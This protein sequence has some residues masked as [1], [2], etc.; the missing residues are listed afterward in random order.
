M[1]GFLKLFI[2][3]SLLIFIWSLFGDLFFLSASVFL[4]APFLFPPQILFVLLDT[5]LKSNERVVSYFQLKKSQLPALAIFHIPDDEHDVL[6]P[7]EISVERVQDFCNRFLQRMQKV[8]GVPDAVVY[9]AL[10]E[11]DFSSLNSSPS[12]SLPLSCTL[13]P[14]YQKS[15]RFRAEQRWMCLQRPCLHWPL[16]SGLQ[17]EFTGLCSCIKVSVKHLSFG[18]SS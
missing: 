1:D 12:P 5:N 9:Q 7:G 13:A 11:G 3:I 10:E 2:K 6:T 16:P 14:E 4:T 18:N 15:I 17:Q 8:K